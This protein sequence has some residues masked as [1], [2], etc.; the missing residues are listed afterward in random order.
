[1]CRVCRLSS[2]V[3]SCRECRTA[4]T[5][6][7]STVTTHVV[8]CVLT[9]V[10]QYVGTLLCSDPHIV[11]SNAKLYY[12]AELGV[13]ITDCAECAV[14][15]VVRYSTSIEYAACYCVISPLDFSSFL[16]ACL[17]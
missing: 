8:V 2:V 14:Q 5:R 10:L 6:H 11:Y 16:S 17:L 4:L 12:R 7:S 3:V 13:E 9:I 1:M 15:R